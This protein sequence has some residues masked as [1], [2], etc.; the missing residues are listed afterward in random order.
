M[1][2]LSGVRWQPSKTRNHLYLEIVLASLSAFDLPFPKTSSR[3]LPFLRGS[4]E[5]LRA[6]LVR[7]VSQEQRRPKGLKHHST[8][9][10]PS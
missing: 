9:T 1:T 5:E 6:L 8:R 10:V 4:Q 3:L 7:A 2:L